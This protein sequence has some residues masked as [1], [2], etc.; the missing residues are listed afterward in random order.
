MTDL[1]PENP[2]SDAVAPARPQEMLSLI[3]LR[4]DLYQSTAAICLQ[5]PITWTMTAA[6][7]VVI[8]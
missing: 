4:I 7:T 3:F 6:A 5:V 8:T 2:G 1:F